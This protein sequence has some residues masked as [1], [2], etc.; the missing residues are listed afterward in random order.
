MN[1]LTK[2]CRR[3]NL[4]VIITTCRTNSI[5]KK[6]IYHKNPNIMAQRSITSFFKVSPPKPS[7]VEKSEVKVTNAGEHVTN[8]KDGEKKPSKTKRLSSSESEEDSPKAAV[9]TSPASDKKKK[10]KRQRIESS[11][12]ESES[13]KEQVVVK[14]EVQSPKS[15][16]SPKSKKKKILTEKKN[17]TK[18]PPHKKSKSESPKK[19]PVA[20]VKV[21]PKDEIVKEEKENGGKD[22][23]VNVGKV[24][25]TDYNPAKVNYDPIKDACWSKGE[26]V[27]YYALAKTLEAIEAISARLKIIGILSNYYR[28]VIALTPEDLLPS[29]YLCLNKLAPAYHSLELGIAETYLMKA[30]GACTGRSLAQVKALAQKS[31]DMG[32]VAEAARATQRTLMA[33]K[34]LTLRRVF[35]T[36]KDIANTTG[37][38]SV[39]KKIN[40]IQSLYVASKNLEARYLIRSLEGKLRIGL[41]EQSVLQALA[42]ATATTPPCDAGVKVLDASKGI[43]AEKFKAIVDEHAILIKTTY[44]ECPNY[45]SIIPVLLKYGV[46]ALP[47]HCKLTPGIPLKPM[48]A[49]PT[50]GVHEIFN[51]FEGQEFTCEWKYDG[52]RA[53]IHVPADKELAAAAVFSRNQ[54]NNT[55]KYPDVLQRL[56]ALLKDS[57]SSCVLDCEAVAY[58]AVEKRIQ[59]FQV[60]ATRKR[61]DASAADIKVQV[62][63]FVFDLLYLNGEPL[64]R[65][66]LA[67]RRRLLQEHFNQVEGVWEFAKSKDCTSIEEVQQFL[68]EA[69]KGSCE[70]LMVKML[71]GENARYDIARR[72]HNWLKL[73]KDYLEGVGDSIDAVVIGGYHGKGKRAGVFGGFLLA[74]HDP[75]NEEYQALC[76]IGTGF[77]DEDLQKLSEQLKQCEIESPR[78]YYR[79]DGAHAPDAW[80]DA[81]CVWE[82][83][84]ADLSLSPAHRAAIG[85]V[86]P[87]KGISLRFPRFVRVRD[88]K[89]AEQATSAQQI[90]EMYLGQDQVKNQANK[91][92]A[93]EDDFY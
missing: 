53:Q 43:S 23:A 12:S 45:D 25:V 86:D 93:R 49:H 58:D 56:P 27:P 4:Y 39:N 75:D 54:E 46:H 17:E 8:G 24:V 16:S 15:Y 35:A 60:L 66:P 80:F 41:A 33:H 65:R 84:C 6:H 76:K 71:K 10:L 7:E 2:I 20:S 5:P 36:L 90:A 18:S 55:S 48:L 13:M 64:V 26:E 50:K 78:P 44:C 73:K 59:P 89:S 30:I 74:C 34:A 61:K 62:C 72:S 70:G 1:S 77:S 37:T 57:V 28:S 40:K 31:G 21:D 63:V 87:D 69:I 42:V 91:V 88:D 68:D 32:R 19:S 67:E 22:D 83:R 85:L 79:Y 38:A 11:E 92:T 82:V 51:R 29:V 3:L 9:K 81:K 14:K 47:D 52:E